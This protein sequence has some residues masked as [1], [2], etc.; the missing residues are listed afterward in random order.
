M[1]AALLS[2]SAARAQ[3]GNTIYGCYGNSNGQL[4]R[5]N[6]PAECKNNETALVWSIQGPKG[7]TGAP[8]PQG[9]QG[10]QGPKGDTG[11]QGPQGPKG[12]KGDPGETPDLTA[13]LDRLAALQAFV[14]FKGPRAYVANN[15]SDN[16]SVIDTTTNAVVA[17]IPVGSAPRG[18][19]LR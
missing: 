16:V 6:S 12:D 19:A 5:V 7:D 10:I 9:P 4:R 15:I 17:T 13:L 2:P 3:S 14:G 18:V 11:A 8:G 1:S